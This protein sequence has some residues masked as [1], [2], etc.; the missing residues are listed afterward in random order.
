MYLCTKIIKKA[1][2]QEKLP[3]GVKW[4]QLPQN[5][6]NRGRLTYLEGDV[7][8]PFPVKRVF[9]ITDVP[10]GKTR[11]GHAHWTCHEAVFPITGRFE[12]ELDDGEENTTVVLDDPTRGITVPAGVWCELRH[13]APGTVCLVMASQE[14]DASGYAL[15]RASWI[16]TLKKEK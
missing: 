13:F 8:I 12:I 15:D 6:D 14:Y 5:V 9:W 10:D 2:E 1:M 11:G 4:I 7:H 16:R 3:L